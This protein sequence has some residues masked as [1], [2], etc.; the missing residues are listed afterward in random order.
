MKKTEP[1]S[2][3]LAKANRFGFF[4]IKRLMNAVAIPK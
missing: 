3:F 4:Y 1:I 2:F